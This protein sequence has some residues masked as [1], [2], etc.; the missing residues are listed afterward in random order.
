[1]SQH[2]A[3]L[4]PGEVSV[5]DLKNPANDDITEDDPESLMNSP[6]IERIAKGQVVMEEIKIE[7]N[8]QDMLEEDDGE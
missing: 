1:V 2:Q 8:I 3:T 7:S 4:A 5:Y 6:L